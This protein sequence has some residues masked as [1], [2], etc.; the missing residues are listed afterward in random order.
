VDR[1]EIILNTYDLSA[2]GDAIESLGALPKGPRSCFTE[3]STGQR[4]IDNGKPS[5][6]SIE[7]GYTFRKDFGEAQGKV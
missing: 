7:K 5:R 6:E 2:Y 3:H 1:S 4:H